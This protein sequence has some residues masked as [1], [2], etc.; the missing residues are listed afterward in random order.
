[1]VAQVVRGYF[2]Y[3]AVPT[4]SKRLNAFRFHVT[5]LWWRTLRGAA[6]RRTGRRGP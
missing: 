5:K 2:L 3:H 1:M 4:N 6:A